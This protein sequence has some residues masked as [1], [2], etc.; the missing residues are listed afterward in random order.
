MRCLGLIR[1]WHS[2]EQTEAHRSSGKCFI[3]IELYQFKVYN[4][5]LLA[6][7]NETFGRRCSRWFARLQT[8]MS[9]FG[10]DLS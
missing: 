7:L 4:S 2:Y 3:F 6:R 9:L 1:S 5:R 10:E 8:K